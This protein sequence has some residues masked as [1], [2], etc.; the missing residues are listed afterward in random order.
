MENGNDQIAMGNAVETVADTLLK[1]LGSDF[2]WEL[3]F[4]ELTED[5]VER[6][7]AYGNEESF[8]AGAGTSDASLVRGRFCQPRR[9]H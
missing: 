4:P 9:E 2:R 7:Q 5:M 3:S 6:F 1:S 8:P